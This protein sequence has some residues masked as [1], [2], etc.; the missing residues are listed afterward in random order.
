MA[1]SILLKEL[2]GHDCPIRTINILDN[3][4]GTPKTDNMYIIANT[5]NLSRSAK[6]QQK[7][8]YFKAFFPSFLLI[9]RLNLSEARVAR[10]FLSPSPPFL[11][12]PPERTVLGELRNAESVSLKESSN[13]VVKVLYY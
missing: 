3:S 4:D 1:I 8:P 13:L 9:F 10:E 6:I 12:A 5:I 7:S 2:L 11:P